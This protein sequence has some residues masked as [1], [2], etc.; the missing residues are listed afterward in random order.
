MI[1]LPICT[2]LLCT[3]YYNIFYIWVILN[4]FS[5]LKISYL[6][7][8]NCQMMFTPS[9]TLFYIYFMHTSPKYAYQ[10][11]SSLSSFCSF[12][13]PSITPLST[14]PFGTYVVA[15]VTW[16]NE[17]LLIYMSFPYTLWAPYRQRL[18]PWKPYNNSYTA[19]NQS[20]WWVNEKRNWK[21]QIIFIINGHSFLLKMSEMI[22]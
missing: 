11:W 16:Y 18:H 1:F 19:G 14:V 10:T 8:N 17:D 15:S 9:R 4:H 12:I 6:P 20:R 21:T 5:Y 13:F 7:S 3:T 22:L 2:V